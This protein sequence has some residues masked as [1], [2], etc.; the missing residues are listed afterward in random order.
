MARCSTGKPAS[1]HTASTDTPNDASMA[2]DASPP[3][4]VFG[5]RRPKQAL[6]RKPSSGASGMR[7][8][9]TI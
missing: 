5:R 9:I 7:A 8:S 6:T 2:A 4:V 1:C 3:E